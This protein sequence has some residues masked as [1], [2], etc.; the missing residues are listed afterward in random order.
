MNEK[1]F[2]SL[3]HLEELRR[4]II[5]CLAAVSA[6]G[7]FSYLRKEQILLLLIKPVGKVFFLTLTEAFLAYLK[8]SIV[9]GIIIASPYIIYQMWAFVWSAFRPI[10]KRYIAIYGV[11]SVLLFATGV[12][13]GYIVGLHAAIRFFLSYAGD[14]LIPI[15]SVNKYINFCFVVIAL[16]GLLFEFPL[17]LAFITSSNLV[18]I[19]RIAAKRKYIIVGI[20]VASAVLTPPDVVTQLLAAV[21]LYLLFEVSMLASKLVRILKV[22]RTRHNFI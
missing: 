15:I 11:L 1:I 4:R 6:A 20:F 19:E 2:P 14:R 22:R 9:S 8:I 13:F 3:A 12:I 16:S 5:Y 7:I 17:I 21:P 10:E 18:A